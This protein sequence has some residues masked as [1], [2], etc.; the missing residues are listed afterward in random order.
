MEI[1]TEEFGELIADRLLLQA[2]LRDFTN[3]DAPLHMQLT[4]K[5]R[6]AVEFAVK[7]RPMGPVEFRLGNLIRR[8]YEALQEVRL[9]YA[10]EVE[11]TGMY[12]SAAAE[13]NGEHPTTRAQL[14][15]IIA[16]RSEP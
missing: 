7:N 3:P 15:Q 14:D 5:E 12:L 11:R 1:T 13:I 10:L 2:L 8:L 16:E 4:I 6:W 9:A